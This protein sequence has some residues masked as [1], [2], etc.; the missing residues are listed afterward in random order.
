M[1]QSMGLQSWH[2]W[3]TEQQQLVP[4]LGNMTLQLLVGDIASMWWVEGQLVWKTLSPSTHAPAQSSDWSPTY[5]LPGLTAPKGSSGV[6]REEAVDCFPDD[7]VPPFPQHRKTPRVH[8]ANLMV[9]QSSSMHQATKIFTLQGTHWLHHF[10]GQK[11]IL[12]LRGRK[13]FAQGH[14][15]KSNCW[16]WHSLLTLSDLKGHICSTS[17]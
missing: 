2:N 4:G 10:Q 9:W 3:A 14:T 12:R 15:K 16:N 1:L 17:H 11:S 8:C 13:W 6:H 5:F 7:M